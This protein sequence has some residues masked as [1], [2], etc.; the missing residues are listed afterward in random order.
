MVWSTADKGKV[1]EG[2]LDTQTL[3]ALEWALELRQTKMTT[4]S[5]IESTRAEARGRS[6]RLSVPVLMY[7]L[8]SYRSYYESADT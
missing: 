1:L 5:C 3:A 6:V 8:E 7:A 4:S 2:P